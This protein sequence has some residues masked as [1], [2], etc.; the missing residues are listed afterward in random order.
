MTAPIIAAVQARRYRVFSRLRKLQMRA[1]SSKKCNR[2]I[3]PGHPLAIVLL[4]AG[5]MK[6]AGP[7]PRGNQIDFMRWRRECLVSASLPFVRRFAMDLR[8]RGIEGGRLVAAV[9]GGPDSVALACALAECWEGPWTI[10]HLNHQLRG[11]ESDFDEQFVRELQA[12]LKAS[13]ASVDLICDRLGIAQLAHTAKANLEATARRARYRWLAEAAQSMQA[14]WVATGHTADDQAETVLH[15]LMRGAGLR[16]LRGIADRRP[17][18]PGLEL[19]R[20]LLG[21]TRA[22]VLDYLQARQQPFRQDSSNLDLRHT[23]NRIRHQLLPL[24]KEGY[25]PGIVTTLSH[26][27]KQAAEANALLTHQATALL[28]QIERPRAGTII[29][30]DRQGLLAVPGYLVREV[31]RLIWERERWPGGRMGFDAW[32][33]LAQLAGQSDGG[34]DFPSGIR[35]SCGERVVRIERTP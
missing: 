32:D 24:L 2:P 12:R 18:A 11:A 22:L 10:A 21:T 35:V 33:R 30:L 15:R 19:V 7:H 26:L 9:S 6:A 17:L 14:H 3:K 34:L 31:F 13:G 25:N 27:A 28:A 5:T 16:G 4:S 8:H 20:P 1:G 29:V 23:R